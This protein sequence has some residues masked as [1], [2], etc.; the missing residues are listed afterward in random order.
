MPAALGKP[1]M[2]SFSGAGR[3][4]ILFNNAFGTSGAAISKTA[5]V[6]AGRQHPAPAIL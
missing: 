5:T 1:S 4:W 2:N 3:R 6:A